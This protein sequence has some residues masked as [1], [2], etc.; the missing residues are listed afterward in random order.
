MSA[1][2]SV[3]NIY[4]VSVSREAQ[5]DG[6]IFSQTLNQF[7]WEGYFGHSFI[8]LILQW[9]K[10]V[11][12]HM[13]AAALLFA[14]AKLN[15]EEIALQKKFL[16]DTTSELGNKFFCKIKGHQN[17]WCAAHTFFST[18]TVNE[19]ESRFIDIILLPNNPSLD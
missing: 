9:R 10:A 6:S 2:S 4:G 14:K 7:A 11:Q 17:K 1:K 12:R 5:T 18:V 3:L 16:M 13:P 8:P 15:R 19:F